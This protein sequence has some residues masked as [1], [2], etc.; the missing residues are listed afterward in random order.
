MSYDKRISSFERLTAY[1]YGNYWIPLHMAIA[2]T[3]YGKTVSD[4]IE[5]LFSPGE[6]NG[7]GNGYSP[8]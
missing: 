8:L 7:C 6:Q 4:Y 3:T 1:S 2:K 5:K